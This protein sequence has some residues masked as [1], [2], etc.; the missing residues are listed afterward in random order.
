MAS[1][2]SGRVRHLTVRADDGL[3]LA[4]EDCGP[5]HTGRSPLLCLAGL[6]RTKRDFTELRDHF[7][8]HPTEPRRVVMMDTRGRGASEWDKDPTRYSVP[9]ESADVTQVAVALGL[10]NTVIVGTSRGGILAMALAVSQAGLIAG[11]VLNDIGPVIAA[12]GIGRLKAQLGGRSLPATW[13]EAALRLAKG[14]SE[15]FPSFD[16]ADWAE[17][18]RRTFAD[19]DG[20]PAPLAD[21]TIGD[22]LKD[23]PDVPQPLDLSIYFRALIRRPVLLIRGEHSDLLDEATVDQAASL[24]AETHTVPDEGHAPWLR[25]PVLERVESFLSANGL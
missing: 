9:R 19:K 20:Y 7:A 15:Q 5:H 21:P 10:H 16:E 4:V 3:R 18:A 17:Y 13:D 22:A 12:K 14:L 24:G 8:F 1:A 11:A 23:I 6:T 25:G 2:L